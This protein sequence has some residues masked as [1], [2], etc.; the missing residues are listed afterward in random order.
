VYNIACDRGRCYIG[1][2]SRPLEVRI[3]EHKY[4]LTQCLLGESKLAEQAYE[5]GQKICWNEAKVLRI[6]AN[7]TDRKYEQFAHMSLTDHPISQSSLDISP[8]WIPVI[9]KTTHTHT[10]PSSAD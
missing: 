5:K 2:T 4:N 6:E 8:I 1:E 9:T 10:T 7:N 3:K